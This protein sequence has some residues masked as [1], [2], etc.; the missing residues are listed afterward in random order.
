MMGREEKQ[1]AERDKDGTGLDMETRGNKRI[2]FS[3]S[4]QDQVG[5]ESI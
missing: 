5:G 4:G 2:V 3:S 1:A